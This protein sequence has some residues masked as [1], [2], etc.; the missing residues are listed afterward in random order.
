MKAAAKSGVSKIVIS[1]LLCA[2]GII[3]P[4]YSPLK[5]LL[6]PASFTLGSHIAIFIA[7]FISP[8]VAVAVSLGTTLGF[9]LGGFPIVIVLRAASHIVFALLGAVILQKRPDIIKSP[10]KSAVFA[11]F[12]GLV[13]A[14]CEVAVVIPFYFGS[15]MSQAY[16]T[17]GFLVSVI[18]LVG[19]GT[20]IHST[21]DFILAYVIWRALRVNN[22][23]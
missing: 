19:V 9:F 22:L 4:L 15:G 2:I 20:V 13:H 21:V 23:G 12:T 8:A 3:I 16:Y 5:I 11:V 7:M 6:E 17:K 10:V 18:L 14:I 1:A